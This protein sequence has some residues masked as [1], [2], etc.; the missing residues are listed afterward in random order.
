MGDLENWAQAIEND[1]QQVLKTLEFVRQASVETPS[2]LQSS[3]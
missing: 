3:S 1:M 2:S